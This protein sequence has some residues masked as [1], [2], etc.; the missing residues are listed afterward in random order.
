MRIDSLFLIPQN[1]PMEST[2]CNSPASGKIAG[3]QSEKY[4]DYVKAGSDDPKES[5][6]LHDHVMSFPT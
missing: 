2:N 3:R 5:F 6:V 4:F 1:S